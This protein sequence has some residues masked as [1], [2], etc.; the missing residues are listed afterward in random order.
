MLVIAFESLTTSRD[1]QLLNRECPIVVTEFGMLTILRFVQISNARVPTYVTE[2][3]MTTDVIFLL[4]SNAESAMLVWS[5]SKNSYA[6]MASPPLYFK[7]YSYYTITKSE[8][9]SYPAFRHMPQTEYNAR[10]KLYFPCITTESDIR[11]IA[12]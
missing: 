1:E 10:L 11:G 5:I 7:I 4:Y 12:S 6:F 2:S 3:G 8:S 9:Q